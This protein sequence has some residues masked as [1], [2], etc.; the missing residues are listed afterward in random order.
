MAPSDAPNEAG[1]V[2][3]LLLTRSRSG[4]RLVFHYPQE[5]QL[6]LSTRQLQHFDTDESGS[7]TDDDTNS[8]AQQQARTSAKVDGN[9]DGHANGRLGNNSL[10]GHSVD[11]L[12]K[13][14]APGRWCD[15]KKFEINLN[16]L[17]FVGHPVYSLEDGA[18]TIKEK[19]AK[20]P[21]KSQ[22]STNRQYA[23]YHMYLTP[24]SLA[25]TPPDPGPIQ[26]AERDFTHMPDS[27][28]S[29]T[30]DKLG[31]SA[32]SHATVSSGGQA[33]EQ[34]SLFHV[35]FVLSSHDHRSLRQAKA[36]YND[37]AKVLSRA[38]YYC[39]KQGNYVSNESRRLSALRAK[40]KQNNWHM[41]ELWRRLIET[42][43]LAW[44]LKEI[45]D[46]VSKGSVAHVRFNGMEMSLHA[47]AEDQQR[48]NE[49]DALDPL[50]ALLFLE[51]KEILLQELSHPDASPLAHFIRE[52]MATKSLEKNAS[53]LGVPVKDVLFLAQ[54]LLKWRKARL[55]PPLHQ[56]N[57]YVV[58]SDAPL[59][60]LTKLVQDY[61]KS[62]PTLPNLPNMLKVL[63]GRPIRYGLLIPS[64]DHRVAY[65]D[66][67]SFL[68]RHRL[69][70]QLK[71]YGWLRLP[72]DL[73]KQTRHSGIGANTRPVSVRSLLSPHFRPTE[74]DLESVISERTAI[75]VPNSK[76][77]KKP[78]QELNESPTGANTTYVVITNPSRPTEEQAHL[79]DVL[80]DRLESPELLEHFVPFLQHLDGKHAFEHIAA[81]LGIKRIKVEEWLADLEDRGWLMS[82]SQSFLAWPL[83]WLLDSTNTNWQ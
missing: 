63:S 59:A 48:D 76:T 1:L 41:S 2:A 19:S 45:F 32:D 8:H 6:P 72:K 67:L 30:I 5:P 18:W 3:V 53:R 28:D 24:E 69:V 15:R 81:R 27:F 21:V 54:H 31:T 25:S 78:G 64:R 17:T 34:M 74:D 57:T 39:Q 12:E 46:R 50:C 68:V 75:A 26:D 61:D 65:M 7:D 29:Q 60:Q 58:S 10:L 23:D 52:H 35:V 9:E 55:I 37:L 43:E 16:G 80:Q 73:A 14:L 51:R 42:S 77:A 20:D 38:L 22:D 33:A 71:Q 49:N 13:L 36:V 40:A 4:P 79:I 83:A 70:V 11:S 82:V 44:A 62:F 47:T 66:I 56:R